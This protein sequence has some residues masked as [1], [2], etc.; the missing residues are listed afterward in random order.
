MF[1]TQVGVIPT[2]I[3]LPAAVARVP[4]TGGGDPVVVVLRVIH[5]Q[6]FPTQVG[7]IPGNRYGRQ[8]STCVPHTGGGDP[9]H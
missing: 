5:Q 7:V 9:A 6:V 2:S 3:T 8:G 4:H 1:P